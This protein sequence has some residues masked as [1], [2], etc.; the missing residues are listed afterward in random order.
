M[1]GGSRQKTQV[2]RL[3]FRAQTARACGIRFVAPAAG[4]V[5]R[6]KQR[7]PR[8]GRTGQ[9]TRTFCANAEIPSEQQSCNE[10]GTRN[11]DYADGN[12]IIPPKRES[13]TVSFRAKKAACGL[14]GVNILEPETFRRRTIVALQEIQLM[15][16]N[17]TANDF[18]FALFFF[19]FKNYMAVDK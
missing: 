9:I 10:G 12:A 8:H 2:K 7:K 4:S 19:G 17:E 15:A 18:R 13:E 1:D 5:C 14:S 3:R 16:S 11:G 6:R